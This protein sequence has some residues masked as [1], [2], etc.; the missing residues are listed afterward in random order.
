MLSSN[1]KTPTDPRPVRPEPHAGAPNSTPFEHA[2]LPRASTRRRTSARFHFAS[3]FR[4]I[5]HFRQMLMPSPVAEHDAARF[6]RTADKMD[7]TPL[8]DVS[9]DS[10]KFLPDERPIVHNRSNRRPVSRR[11]FRRKSSKVRGNVR[12][13]NGWR[14]RRPSHRTG[15]RCG[16]RGFMEPIM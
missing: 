15:Q 16:G 13:S 2:A 11:V 8:I 5:G 4:P 9:S 3:E 6:G 14:S 12:Q 1:F 7:D 10:R